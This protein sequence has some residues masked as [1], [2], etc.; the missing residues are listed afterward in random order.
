M[1]K[2]FL[3]FAIAFFFQLAGYAQKNAQ[4]KIDSLLTQYKNAKEDTLKIRLLA[5]VMDA[6]IYFKP[7]EGLNYQGAA[8]QLA[9]KANWPIG[10]AKIK[11]RLGR[12]NWR[13]GNFGQHASGDETGN[14]KFGETFIKGMYFV[15][16]L[17]KDGYK[18]LKVVKQ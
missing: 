15:K 2:Q 10:T 14:D 1:K 13:M 9:Q 12:L 5:E 17:Y 8:M 4:A 11:D 18:V 3:L 6:Y 16:V 7:Q